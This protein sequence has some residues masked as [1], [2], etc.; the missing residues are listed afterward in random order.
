MTVLVH[1]CST[2]V[3]TVVETVVDCTATLELKDDVV[4]T[5]VTA[6]LDNVVSPR[7]WLVED[8]DEVGKLS[9]AST[10]EVGGLWLTVKVEELVLLL[11][12]L[13]VVVALDVEVNGKESPSWDTRED[14]GSDMVSR[15]ACSVVV[16][17]V[18]N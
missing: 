2:V 18:F 9:T 1:A 16:P 17:T 6:S 12:R 13:D 3:E 7:L 4:A 8:A 15:E 10:S 11:I 14:S 5:F